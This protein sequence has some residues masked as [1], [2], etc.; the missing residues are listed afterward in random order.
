MQLRE[1]A[2]VLRTPL[3]RLLA[4]SD[5]GTLDYVCDRLL[6]AAPIVLDEAPGDSSAAEALE[7]AVEG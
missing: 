4:R 2:P 5:E 1:E 3:E 6:A 7:M